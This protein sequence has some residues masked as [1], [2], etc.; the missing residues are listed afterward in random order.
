MP[1]ILNDKIRITP[2]GIITYSNIFDVMAADCKI[3]S[4]I[5][6]III[7]TILNNAKGNSIIFYIENYYLGLVKIYRLAKLVPMLLKLPVL[8]LSHQKQINDLKNW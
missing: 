5:D 6:S 8:P 3:L 1:V 2:S 4:H 7:N